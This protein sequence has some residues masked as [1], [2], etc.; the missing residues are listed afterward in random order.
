M[1]ELLSIGLQ[2]SMD[3]ADRFLLTLIRVLLASALI[4][5]CLLCQVFTWLGYLEYWVPRLLR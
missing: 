3:R 2:T 5:A 1:A 4:G